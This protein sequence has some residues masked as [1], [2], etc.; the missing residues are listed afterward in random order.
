L[1]FGLQKFRFSCFRTDASVIKSAAKSGS[2]PRKHKSQGQRFFLAVLWLFLFVGLMAGCSMWS[3]FQAQGNLPTP[4]LSPSLTATVTP[5]PTAPVLATATQKPRVYPTP[6]IDPITPV[7]DP[8]S[9]LQIPDELRLLV[10]LGTD[11]PSPYVSRT[12]AVML[13][14]YNPRLAKVALLSLPPEMFVYIPGYTMQRLNIAYPLGGFPLLADTIE[15]NIGVRPDEFA[16]IHVDDFAWF[17]EEL[18][19][20]DVDVFRNY[21]DFCGGIPAGNVHLQGG[22]VLCYV[23]FRDGWD[24][25][26]QAERQQQVA[27]RLFMR[28]VGGG[29]LVEMEDF[30]L[31]YKAVVESNLDLSDLLA[32]IPLALRLGQVDRFGFFAPTFDM[33]QTWDLPGDVQATVLLPRGERLIQMVQQAIDFTMLSV[34]TSDIIL[35]LEY[36]LTISPTPT[37]TPTASATST[38]TPTL[39]I[40][41]SPVISVT[42]TIT[43]T[44]TVEGSPS[45]S[46]TP[47]PTVT[48]AGYP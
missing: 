11:N 46:I 15:Y 29:K 24:I 42:V 17:V 26:D 28:M 33:F 40:T 25:R 22:D 12:D 44:R 32:N 5:S 36:E 48:T 39:T 7:P 1:R 4:S 14:F 2:I 9:G 47:S 20:L 30:Y 27:W 35:T 13:A 34:K 16:V 8:V 37:N 43:G 45:P 21:Y 3:G 10:L 19:G 6:R 41:P 18:Q 38:L 31:T 23:K